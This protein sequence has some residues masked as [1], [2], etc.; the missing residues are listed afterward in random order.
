MNPMVFLGTGGGDLT[1][2]WSPPPPA[3]APAV[4]E[5]PV[6]PFL[7]PIGMGEVSIASGGLIWFNWRINI[8]KW[9]YHQ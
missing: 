2:P 8:N 5:A 6:A 3:P 7:G 4:E 1:W 9:R